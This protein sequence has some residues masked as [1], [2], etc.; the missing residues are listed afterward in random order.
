MNTW[1]YYFFHLLLSFAS[2]SEW[3]PNH[4]PGKEGW[5]PPEILKNECIYFNDFETIPAWLHGRLTWRFLEGNDSIYDTFPISAFYSLCLALLTLCLDHNAKSLLHL[6]SA[7][8]KPPLCFVVALWNRGGTKT[9]PSLLRLPS[10]L[11][12]SPPASHAASGFSSPKVGTVSA[13]GPMSE[14]NKPELQANNEQH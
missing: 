6:T 13:P 2:A 4:L 3:W 11:K 7:G 12:T 10:Y 5:L 1:I 14:P 9:L 8:W